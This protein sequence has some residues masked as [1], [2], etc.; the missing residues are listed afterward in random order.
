MVDGGG[1]YRQHSQGGEHRKNRDEQK[2]RPLRDGPS[3]EA[4]RRGNRDIAA[5]IP[6]GIAAH[7]AGQRRTGVEPQGQ[8]RDRRPEHVAH[9]RH[10]GVGD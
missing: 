7:S 1:R 6:G 10:D 5:M 4:R 3:D 8:C 9:R 2:H